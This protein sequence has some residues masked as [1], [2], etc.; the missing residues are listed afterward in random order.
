MLS[1]VEIA[2]K[3]DHSITQT[4]KSNCKSV[5]ATGNYQSNAVPTSE[6]SIKPLPMQAVPYTNVLPNKIV[7]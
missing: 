1:Q 5:A 6:E 7:L 4:S 3:A 2:I